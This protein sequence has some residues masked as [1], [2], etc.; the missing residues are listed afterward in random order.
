M[1]T[2]VALRTGSQARPLQCADGVDDAS[3]DLR[4]VE[5]FAGQECLA[6][7]LE[8][9][10]RGTGQRILGQLAAQPFRLGHDRGDGGYRPQSL[11]ASGIDAPSLWGAS[12]IASPLEVGSGFDIAGESKTK[13]GAARSHSRCGRGE[14]I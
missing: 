12:A 3:L 2:P 6:H 13:T 8:L 5:R 4:S 9:G 7:V 1:T 10:S 11:V 14:R